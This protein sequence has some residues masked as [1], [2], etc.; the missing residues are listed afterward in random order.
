MLLV[1]A[2]L[3]TLRAFTLFVPVARV[4]ALIALTLT[5]LS[6]NL[7]GLEKFWAFLQYRKDK[8]PV[9]ILPELETILANFK[10]LDDFHAYGSVRRCACMS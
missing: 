7:Y 10:T 1:A 2:N 5:C 6:D 8:R 4:S 3:F 9:K